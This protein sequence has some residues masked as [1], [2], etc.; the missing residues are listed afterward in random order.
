MLHQDTV[1]N[2]RTAITTKIKRCPNPVT[3]LSRSLYLNSSTVTM[4]LDLATPPSESTC[5]I[6]IP[7]N[8]PV[9]P[10]SQLGCSP[11]SGSIPT[12]HFPPSI[13]TLCSLPVELEEGKT[14]FYKW[15]L[16]RLLHLGQSRIPETQRRVGNTFSGLQCKEST[17]WVQDL[18]VSPLSHLASLRN[19]LSGSASPPLGRDGTFYF[20]EASGWF[21]QINT[22]RRQ[23]G[24][25]QV[26]SKRELHLSLSDFFL[27][28]TQQ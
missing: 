28:V 11:L 3:Q 20:T 22:W 2:M 8:S 15:V 19:S 1:R 24:S 25:I 4:P 17:C 5:F 10:S 16:W 23:W 6:I 13:T 26:L 27:Q 12:R 7:D 18:S 21:N 9:T 14:G